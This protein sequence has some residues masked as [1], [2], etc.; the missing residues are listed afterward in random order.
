MQHTARVDSVVARDNYYFAVTVFP[1]GFGGGNARCAGTNNYIFH[2]ATS[3]S[4]EATASTRMAL[5][6]QFFT[7]LG[8]PSLLAQK[9]HFTMYVLVARSG[10]ST[11]K[12]QFITHIKH[13]AHLSLS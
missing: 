2:F 4:L 6:G 1:N 10:L 5:V 8:S 9:S 11:P 13:W 7:Q 3:L 12:G